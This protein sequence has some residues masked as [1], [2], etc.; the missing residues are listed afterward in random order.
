[1]NSDFIPDFDD[2]VSTVWRYKPILVLL[3]AGGFI[4]FVLV[5]IDTHRHRKKQKGRHKKRL[6]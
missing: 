6:H 4:V 3:V 5:V 2:L 1:M